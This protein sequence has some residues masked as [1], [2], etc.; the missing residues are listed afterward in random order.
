[1]DSVEVHIYIRMDKEYIFI[2]EYYSSIKIESLSF[3]ETWIKLR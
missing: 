1:M 3:A 2:I